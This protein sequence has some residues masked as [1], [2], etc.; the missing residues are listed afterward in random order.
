MPLQRHHLV[1]KPIG[2]HTNSGQVVPLKAIDS[3]GQCDY[4]WELDRCR[5]FKPST[6][7]LGE[8]ANEALEARFMI[9]TV[10]P[11]FMPSLERS[12]HWEI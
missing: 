12:F 5:F 8:S 6:V 1:G 9:F 10:E 3:V 2:S 7:V 11:G 4:D